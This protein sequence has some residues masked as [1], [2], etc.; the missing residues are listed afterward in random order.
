MILI[1]KV[2]CKLKIMSWARDVTEGMSAVRIC[3]D[4]CN[5]TQDILCIKK[6]NSV[7]NKTSTIKTYKVFFFSTLQAQKLFQIWKHLMEIFPLTQRPTRRLELS[8]YI[9]ADLFFRFVFGL[10]QRTK[11]NN[12]HRIMS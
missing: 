8:R 3:M 12:N 7:I 11:T 4:Q 2:S 1:L 9:I 6:K 10:I 5:C